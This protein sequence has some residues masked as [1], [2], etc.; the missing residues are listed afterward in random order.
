MRSPW[1]SWIGENICFE[2]YRYFAV[3]HHA[4]QPEPN[5]H[6]YNQSNFSQVIQLHNNTSSSCKAAIIKS[7]LIEGLGDSTECGDNNSYVPLST[8][9]V[10]KHPITSERSLLQKQERVTKLQDA[11][12]K[13]ISKGVDSLKQKVRNFL[14]HLISRTMNIYETLP[15]SHQLRISTV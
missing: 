5:C 15:K 11:M 1:V 3:S 4:L 13:D 9:I 12:L 14:W 6:V 10:S 7:D 2:V 8:N